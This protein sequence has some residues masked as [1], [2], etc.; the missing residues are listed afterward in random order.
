ME[1]ISIADVV[2]TVS[3][4]YGYTGEI[5]WNSDKPSG[6]LRKPS[7]TTRFMSEFPLAINTAFND[8][9]A[10]TCKWFEDNYPLVRGM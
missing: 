7:S 6:Q 1:E 9:I 4:Y 5:I 10:E 2:A 8:G 3:K